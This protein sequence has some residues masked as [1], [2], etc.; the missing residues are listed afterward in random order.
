MSDFATPLPDT[1]PEVGLSE[2]E[3]LVDTFIAP[4]KTF[5]DIRR[6]SSWWVPFVLTCLLSWIFTFTVSKKVGWEAVAQQQIHASKSSAD[7]F[8][9]LPP[10]T[11]AKQ[12]HMAGTISTYIGYAMPVMFFI[13]MVVM[14]VVLW[15]SVNFGLGA[16]TKFWQV[17]AVLTYA[18]LP[19][20]FITLLSIILLWAGVGVDN[21][22]IKNPVGTNLGYYL[23]DS[24]KWLQSFGS[25]F[26]I[27]SLWML[28]LMIIGLAVIG[29][30]TK[31]QTAIIV[32]GWWALILL[33]SVG[34]AAVMG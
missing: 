19:K 10:E 21:F 23:T 33:V 14:T 20:I 26:D 12:I 4:T 5:M 13:I 22:D 16:E 32:L 7:R 2:V 1:T 27:F 30:K 18:G 15:M 6:S 34:W 28:A 8:D 24:P 3:R 25:Y 11:Q 9:Q 31:G 17:F 29:K